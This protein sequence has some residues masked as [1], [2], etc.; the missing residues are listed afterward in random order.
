MNFKF[1]NILKGNMRLAGSK[2]MLIFIV[3]FV[4]PN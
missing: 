1:Y 2:G 4:S 3:P